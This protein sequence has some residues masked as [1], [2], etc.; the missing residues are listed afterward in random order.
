MIRTMKFDVDLR[1]KSALVTG[2]SS[3]LGMHFAQVLADAGAKI[4]LAA[5]NMNK[6]EAI[7]CRIISAGGQAE[8][9]PLDVTSSESVNMI[10]PY[11]EQV[12]IVVNNAGIVRE[13]TLLDMP[14][15]DWDAVL[16]TNAKGIFLT[17]Q[18]AARAMKAHGRGGSIINIASILALR[19]AGMVTSYAASKAA[20]IQITKTSA[21]ELA[22]YG[23]RVNALAP[24]YFDTELNAGFFQSENG[25]ALIKRIPQ[26]RLG[27]LEDLDGP[28]LLLASDASAYMTG[29]VIEVDG[30]HL[31]NSL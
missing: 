4:M 1:G 23:I 3:G 5:R 14:E 27:S 26:R 2:A 9:I 24:G 16:D 30:G 11:L 10:A 17:T 12:D 29:S 6:L 18:L 20:A 31:V 21:L 7:S 8:A 15:D 22:R 25:R 13:A 28:L 19:Q